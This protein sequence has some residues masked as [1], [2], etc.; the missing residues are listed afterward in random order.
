MLV[1]EGQAFTLELHVYVEDHGYMSIEEDVLVTRDGC[2]FL[3][4]R[5][6]ELPLLL[7]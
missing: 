2:K 3:S 4:N 7:L 6:L 5:Q 1:E